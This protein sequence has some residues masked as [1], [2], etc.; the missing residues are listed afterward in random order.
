MSNMP[1]HIMA[2]PL[3]GSCPHGWVVRCGGRTEGNQGQGAD[4]SDNAAS[5]DTAWISLSADNMIGP[6]VPCKDVGPFRFLWA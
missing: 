6:L 4:I 2:E 3:L 1:E 5:P